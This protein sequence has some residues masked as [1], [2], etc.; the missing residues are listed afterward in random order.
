MKIEKVKNE[1]IEKFEDLAPGDAFTRIPNHSSSDLY[2]KTY[3]FVCEDAYEIT[4][5]V[6]ANEYNAIKLSNGEPYWFADY[7]KVVV[8]NCKIVVE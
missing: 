5:N 3:D 1:N 7:D 8:P 4:D 2:I 6:D